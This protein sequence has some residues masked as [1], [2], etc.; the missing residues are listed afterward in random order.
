MPDF[1]AYVY[2]RTALHHAKVA[3]LAFLIRQS[4]V[5]QSGQAH[6]ILSRHINGFASGPITFL[7]PV[8][9]SAI[10]ARERLISKNKQGVGLHVSSGNEKPFPL[11][12]KRRVPASKT[13]FTRDSDRFFSRP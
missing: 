9:L 13:L 7:S 3:A 4:V 12:N 1:A 5:F 10:S 11:A 8:W 6:G 2:E